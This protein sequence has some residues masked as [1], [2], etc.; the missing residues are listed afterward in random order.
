MAS[1]AAVA[2]QNQLGHL[3]W[4]CLDLKVGC[5]NWRAFSSGN[6]PLPDASWHGVRPILFIQAFAFEGGLWNWYGASGSGVLVNKCLQCSVP[7]E[8]LFYE[9]S[10]MWLQSA[11]VIQKFSHFLYCCNMLLSRFIFFH[12]SCFQFAL[13]KVLLQKQNVKVGGFFKWK[14][15][16]VSCKLPPI[17]FKCFFVLF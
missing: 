6:N 16:I 14:V 13:C 4:Q 5:F 7:W 17:K 11:R 1:L 10:W 9:M 3:C 12:V 15:H 2:T 8:F